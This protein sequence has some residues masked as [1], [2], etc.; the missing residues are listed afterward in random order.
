MGR[1]N[2]SLS[3]NQALLLEGAERLG[4]DLELD[5]L[6]ADYDSLVLKVGLP[7]FLGVALG[8]ADIVAV[9][10]ALAGYITFLHINPLINDSASYFT[11]SANRCQ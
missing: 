9:L 10:L 7:D 5:L 11:L 8:K 3:A 2:L 1:T 4:A 6:A